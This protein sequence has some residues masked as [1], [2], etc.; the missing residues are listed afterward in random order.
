MIYWIVSCNSYNITNLMHFYLDVSKLMYR[1]T[2]NIK[3]NGRIQRG[4]EVK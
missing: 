1:Y 2:L 3:Y 4:S